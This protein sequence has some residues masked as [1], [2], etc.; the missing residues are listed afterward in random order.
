[1]CV[2]KDIKNSVLF[3]NTLNNVDLIIAGIIA[4]KT[5]KNIFF[6]YN[7]NSELPRVVGI[8]GMV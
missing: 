5:Y 8:D 3:Y 6:P 4:L 1:L 2:I 7:F